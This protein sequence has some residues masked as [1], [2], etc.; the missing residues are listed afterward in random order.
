[1]KLFSLRALPVA[2]LFV[3]LAACK[4][5]EKDAQQ[6]IEKGKALQDQGN[7]ELAQVQFKIALRIQPKLADTY[8]RLAL[9]D[10]QKQDLQG[11]HNNLTTAISLDPKHI[12]A[13]LKLGQL[14][15][16]RFEFEKAHTEA[17]TVLQL[18][19]GQAGGLTLRTATLFSQ[20]KKAE[21]LV[22]VS[23]GSKNNP[24]HYDDMTLQASIHLAGQRYAE[25]LAI[26][27]R[28]IELNPK[29]IG[30][31]LMKIRAEAEIGDYNGAVADYQ[32]LMSQN[33][34]ARELISGM[35]ALLLAV[36]RQEQAEG[37]LLQVIDKDAYNVQAK[38]KL[39]ELIE[40]RNEAEAERM[41]MHFVDA[42]PKT[43][44][45]LAK[46]A[47]FYEA[48]K[49]YTD[50]KAVLNRIFQLEKTGKEGL[51]AKTKLARIAL[52]QS[53]GIK[54]GALI[55]EVLAV[56][57]AN[58]EALLLRATMR[59]DQHDADAAIA[60]LRAALRAQPNLTAAH[61]MLARAYSQKG[62]LE[63]ATS[64]QRKAFENDTTNI[65]AVLPVVTL[66]L[67]EGHDLAKAEQILESALAANS[68]SRLGL[69]RGLE[70]LAQ[71]RTAR[72]N[73]D[74][75]QAAVTELG[76]LPGA[77]AAALFLSGEILSKQGNY[78]DAIKKYQQTLTERPNF[79]LAIQSIAQA[80]LAGG[81]STQL[82]AY[83]NSFIERNPN[84]VE[85]HN[86]L[87]MAYGVEKKWADATKVLREALVMDPKS[88]S[89]YEALAKVYSTQNKPADAADVYRK[90][91]AELPDNIPLRL[92]L[93]Q[94][95]ATHQDAESA[96]AILDE[97][98]EKYPDS[99]MAANSLSWLLATNRT[100]KESLEWASQLAERFRTSP[101]PQLLDTYAW[102]SLLTGNKDSAVSALKQ[103][104]ETVPDSALF[105]Y[106]LGIAYY[107]ASKRA[108][109]KM[110]LEKSIAL[111][112][113]NGGF[114][115]LENAGRLVKELSVTAS[116]KRAEEYR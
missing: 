105:Q 86:V 29:D 68:G 79:P 82:I 23:R 88:V 69:E 76:R 55:A 81:N 26:L 17:A 41:L 102:V 34:D 25:A 78:A 50:A 46:A 93:A 14:Y 8:Y 39:V 21:S 73:W 10:E 98:V 66:M 24:D 67:Q 115:G 91:L 3:L 112:K 95:Y 83:I 106:Y 114:L 94:H 33:P 96:I 72:K 61:M 100:D 63:L 77:A 32:T 38:L 71:V 101:S 54:A 75:A 64:T 52:A 40:H 31:Q 85:A 12:E 57:S 65:E 70:M 1:M 49:R 42:Q 4:G 58:P 20:W 99:D 15:L 104:V 109:A 51:S 19:P 74:G 11:M 48:H 18:Q 108:E 116:G 44:P 113:Q 80:Y 107:Q 89:T 90:G 28:D 97:T 2:F 47:D 59:L 56:D 103:V 43:L 5:T 111:A 13:H 84:I 27:K 35:V 60:D 36:G 37:F 53:D 22:V 92:D 30:I 16:I 110:S 7:I 45:L 9:V 87:G 6:Y 62:Y